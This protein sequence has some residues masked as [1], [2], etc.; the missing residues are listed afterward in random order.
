MA[1][2]GTTITKGSTLTTAQVKGMKTFQSLVAKR[3]VVPV[4][5]TSAR[6]L[7]TARDQS[8]TLPSYLTDS[9]ANNAVKYIPTPTYINPAALSSYSQ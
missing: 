5:D 9:T 4:P 7:Q 8:A 6:R 1:Y 2:K 3:W